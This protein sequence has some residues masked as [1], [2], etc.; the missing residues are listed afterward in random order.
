M[1]M[2]ANNIPSA[3]DLHVEILWRMKRSQASRKCHIRKG[4]FKFDPFTSSDDWR[5][6][7][8]AFYLSCLLSVEQFTLKIS[9]DLISRRN[10][11]PRRN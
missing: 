7:A 10:Q 9:K 2:E 6:A 5:K 1:D 4:D 11:L 8:H 3:A